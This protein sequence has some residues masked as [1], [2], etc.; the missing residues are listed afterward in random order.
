MQVVTCPYCQGNCEVVSG[1]V[2]YQS[3]PDLVAL[4]FWRCPKPECDAYV[5]C[6]KAGDY[7]FVNGKKVVSDGTLP[8]GT[9]ANAQLRMARQSVHKA[10]DPFWKDQGFGRRQAYMML[11]QGMDR[12][13]ETTHIAMFT[14]DD[15]VKALQIVEKLK[16]RNRII[17]ERIRAVSK[18]KMKEA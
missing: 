10:F 5:G 11:A 17:S 2:I 3:R 16:V 12:H 18:F 6:H 4:N 7:T 14:L 9:P 1:N 15:C 8:F 13:I